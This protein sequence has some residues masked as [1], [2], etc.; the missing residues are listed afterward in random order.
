MSTP[1]ASQS[2][3]S[4]WLVLVHQ[5]P[6]SPAYLRVKVGR[7]LQRVGAVAI[8]N[9]VYALPYGEEAQE[10]FRWVLAE[11]SKG[12]GDGTVF[13]AHLVGGWATSS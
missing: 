7:H 1:S 6:P 8:K 10:D 2:L 12:G 4:K 3:E 13:G 9:S 11:V 5:I